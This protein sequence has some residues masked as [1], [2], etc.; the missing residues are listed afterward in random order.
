MTGENR[1]QTNPQKM[2]FSELSGNAGQPGFQSK[3]AGKL[4][5]SGG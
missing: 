4:F 5:F 1:C 2:T 3:I